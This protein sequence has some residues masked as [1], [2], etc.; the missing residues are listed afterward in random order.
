LRRDISRCIVIAA[1]STVVLGGPAT[2]GALA[3]EGPPVIVSSYRTPNDWG[4]TPAGQQVDTRRTPDGV[5]VS[6][7]GKTAFA[8]ANSQLDNALTTIDA[9]T[10]VASPTETSATYFG[11]AADS[12]N[13]WAS[14]GFSNKIYQFS[15]AAGAGAAVPT[16]Q[17]SPVP[18]S[19]DN[20]IPVLSYPGNMVL[21]QAGHRLFVAGS[22]SVPSAAITAFDP[23]A[24]TCTDITG[25]AT[26]I[27]SVINVVDVSNTSPTVM[28][29]V[30]LVAV[31]RDAYGVALSSAHKALYVTNM[32]DQTSSA[33]T[34]TLSVVNIA[35][36][37][38]ESEVQRVRVGNDPLGVTASP[39]GSRVVVANSADDTIT[40]MRVNSHGKLSRGR[41]YSVR[42]YPGEP[43]GATP[44][45]VAYS[46][47]GKLLYVALAGQNAIQVRNADGTSIKQRRLHSTNSYIPA[48]WYPDAL[49]VGPNP[50]G[51]SGSRLYVSNL[52]GLGMGPGFDELISGVRSEGNVSVIEVP[53]DAAGR[54][55]ML[56]SAT[57]QVIQNNGWAPL[58]AASDPTIA[59]NDSCAP[60]PLP[61]GGQTQG[62]D[63]ICELAQNPAKRQQ[64]HVVYIVKENKT[65]DQYFG[66]IQATLPS[67]DASP[68]WLLYG[69]PVTTNQHRLA[70]QFTL[71][72]RFWADS[73]QSTT[74]HSWT[75]AGYT[76]AY[77]E[78]FWETSGGYDEGLRGNRESCQYTGQ[79]S[80]PTYPGCPE[81]S[82]YP[83]Q[84]RLVDEIATTPGLTERIY[85]ND[86]D[87][88]SPAYADRIP[89]GEWGF[90]GQLIQTG[91]NLEFPDTDRANLLINGTTISH[92]WDVRNGPP[93]PTYGKPF[94]LS[95]PARFSLNGPGGW[96]DQYNI[97][98]ANGG[99]DASCQAQMPNFLYVSL[100]VD[101][102][103]GYDP[104]TPTPPSMVADN[105]Y[106]TGQVIDALS[107]SPFWKNTLIFVTEDDTQAS[108]DHVDGHRTFL[109][110]SGGLA[111]QLGPQ[112][113]VSHQ[114][115]SF[116]SVLKTVEDMFGLGAL[117]IYDRGAHALHDV[118][119]DK[120]ADANSSQY[121]AV[122][123]PTP[124][125]RNPSLSEADAGTAQLE[126]LSLKANFW[127]LDLGNPVLEHD[128]LYAGLRGT[129]L[130]SADL[131]LIGQ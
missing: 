23:S 22:L 127:N 37:G 83:P 20:G 110:T 9:N 4:L 90:N 26:G 55:S 1:A 33:G 100:P 6:P 91:S 101:H 24:A 28:P 104:M 11:A 129:P 84:K 41:T 45:A 30:H 122:Q 109:L 64:V 102:T 31:G 77:N 16:R 44:T 59:G 79:R 108:G 52:K 32:A 10:L 42:A 35:V 68:T 69:E 115:G 12:S 67:A 50:S 114:E 60:A 8:L 58:L 99:N 107:R 43:L 119:V 53:D 123:P 39:D 49:A 56:A 96:T 87:P 62:S 86:V 126:Q 2:A 70:Q 81:G 128:I 75:S 111:R 38:R 103:L 112:G 113:Q 5:A 7:D 93:P 47:D 25:N 66:D 131:A 117:T 124:F 80:G 120:L 118:V 94:S 63:V 14:G 88:S 85:S 15:Y 40:V 74:G 121:T 46:P 82:M 98:M 78:L 65:F 54:V 27:C 36:P 48:G 3:L 61:G 72:D 29:H 92:A 95:Q 106:A 57:A 116:P 125:V 13:V 76:T 21:D 97:C 130:P 105:D 73:E 89:L 19:P 17:V 18:G 51:A 71:S 34:G